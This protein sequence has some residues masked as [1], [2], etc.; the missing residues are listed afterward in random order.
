MLI[1]ALILNNLPLTGRFGMSSL[2]PDCS[3]V[4]RTVRHS[5]TANGPATVVIGIAEVVAPDTMGVGV[6]LVVELLILP[7]FKLL[8]LLLLI[9]FSS[10]INAKCGGYIVDEVTKL[11]RNVDTRNTI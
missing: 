6:A 5:C 10:S 8:L 1:K 3:K 9:R 11:H 2:S 4:V 7:F